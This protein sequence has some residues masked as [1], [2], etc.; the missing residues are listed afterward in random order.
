MLSLAVAQRVVE[1]GVLGLS[2]RA[3]ARRLR[4]SRGSVGVILRGTWAGWR[5]YRAEGPSPNGKP[6]RCPTCGRLVKLPCLACRLEKT[7]PERPPQ[8]EQA[9]TETEELGVDL[10][11]AERARYQRL[12]RARQALH[13]A[14]AQPAEGPPP[15][16]THAEATDR[17]LTCCAR[18]L[19]PLTLRIGRQSVTIYDR[20]TA[21]PVRRCPNCHRLLPR[22]TPEEIYHHLQH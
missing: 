8:A 10:R 19:W 18:C 22:L 13:Q 3:I 2:Q 6:G 12:R 9:P 5:R 21:R 14:T 15:P 17:V 20:N 1:L 7:R 11:G 16:Q 4:I